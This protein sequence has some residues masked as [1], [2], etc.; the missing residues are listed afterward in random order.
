MACHPI[1]DGPVGGAAMAKHVV[2]GTSFIWLIGQ[3]SRLM[4]SRLH[5]VCMYLKPCLY[6]NTQDAMACAL[7]A[8][9]GKHYSSVGL[10]W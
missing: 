5:Q 4:D 7:F 6:S 9:V 3:V 8:R 2:I 10:V 1:F